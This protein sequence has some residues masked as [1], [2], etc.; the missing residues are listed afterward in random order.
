M[1]NEMV[2]IDEIIHRIHHSKNI[3][4]PYLD[5]IQFF[6]KNNNALSKEV[7]DWHDSAV[8]TKACHPQLSDEEL[9]PQNLKET[10][11]KKNLILQLLKPFD[12]S[13]IE[14]FD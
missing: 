13:E 9:F 14:N 12:A 11:K 3:L 8:V 1:E 6:T 4:K 10:M 2:S 7:L 5:M